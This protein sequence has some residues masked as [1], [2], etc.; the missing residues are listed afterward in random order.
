MFDRSPIRVLVVDDHP[1]FRHGMVEALKGAGLDVVAEAGSGAEALRLAVDLVPEVVV[2]DID[3]PEMDG[4]ELA[5]KLT[6]SDSPFKVAILTMHKAENTFHSA[7]EA[8]ALAYILKDESVSGI[9]GGI[10]AASRG[11]QY[12]S[13]AL[14]P[15]IMKRSRQVSK[16]QKE[17]PGLDQLT[18]AERAV[19]KLVAQ[20][21]MSKEIADE[22]G[23]SPRTV[24]RHRNNISRKLELS[25]KMPL[26]NWALLHQVEIMDLVG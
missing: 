15:V 25:G 8:G 7:V 3:M 26:L 17:V 18:P 21:R 12:I 4:L 24:D 2:T 1:M 14:A 19:L 5:A 22:L 6:S 20:N 13:P 10:T 23:I 11:E 16:L 9:V